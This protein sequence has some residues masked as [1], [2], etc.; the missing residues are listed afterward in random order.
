MV[1]GELD[2]M[3]EGIKMQVGKNRNGNENVSKQA[4]DKMGREHVFL[5]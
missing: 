2:A 1:N 3:M 4:T 5:C